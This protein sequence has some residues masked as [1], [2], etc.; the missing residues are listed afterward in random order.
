MGIPQNDLTNLLEIYLWTQFLNVTDPLPTL[1]TASADVMELTG[2]QQQL[3]RCF[4]LARKMGLD[5][6][7]QGLM[8]VVTN[9]LYTGPNSIDPGRA[10]STLQYVLYRGLGVL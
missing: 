9:N 4:A 6:N 3:I 2:E 5:T 8:N 7:W 10:P 1:F